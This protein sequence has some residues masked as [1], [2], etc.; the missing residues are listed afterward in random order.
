MAAASPLVDPSRVVVITACSVDYLTGYL[1]LRANAIWAERHQYAFR[2]SFE[3]PGD[4]A[5]AIRPRDHLTWYKVVLIQRALANPAWDW[6]VWIDADA[7]V[8]H[9]DVGIDRLIARGGD[10]VDLIIGE[11]ISPSC[12]VNAGVMLIRRSEWSRRVWADVWDCRR[13]QTK[14]FHEQS[15][16]CRWLKLHEEGFGA[17][18][19][20]YSWDGAPAAGHRTH[21]T[22]VLPH[23][24]INTNAGSAGLQRHKRAHK[25]AAR[26]GD[27]V[28]PA[29]GSAEDGLGGGGP[30]FVFHAV[31]CSPK[32]AAIRT[33][34]AKHGIAVGLDDAALEMV[35]PRLNGPV[36][37]TIDKARLQ[38]LADAVVV[39]P[40]DHLAFV[41]LDR[42]S[43]GPDD[44]CIIAAFLSAGAPLR[45]INLS[46][47]LIG[48]AGLDAVATAVAKCH[49]LGSLRV[50]R[51]GATISGAGAILRVMECH[52]ELRFV[53]MS[54]NAL[55][56]CDAGAAGGKIGGGGADVR[57]TEA[58]DTVCKARHAGKVE[59][60]AVREHRGYPTLCRR[61]ILPDGRALE[62]MW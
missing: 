31:G 58:V 54:G 10:D 23:H 12:R 14:A 35:H 9:H 59:Q 11:D 43:L 52:P 16:L 51:V 48:D 37:G 19:P 2:P 30:Q 36:P 22:L 8:V 41:A 27:G 7:V 13:W 60:V 26:I 33:A 62:M 1:C 50:E 39:N 49:T 29:D 17:P 4:M 44:V 28:C 34:L 46:F 3:L 25:M 6:V 21:K 15:A 45:A 47:N 57:I 53:D 56:A 40:P 38:T 18:A 5:A 24:A 32:L 61:G 42:C 55:G 20:W